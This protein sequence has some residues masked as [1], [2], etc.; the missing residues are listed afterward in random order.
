MPL[1]QA[2]VNFLM[3][4]AAVI[5]VIALSGCLVL[6]SL[7]SSEATATLARIMEATG[8]GIARWAA[9]GAG[10]GACCCS[11]RDQQRLVY[12]V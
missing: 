2:I 11:T 9:A 3:C 4:T 1:L 7:A 5:V 6:P 12:K 8:A 10:A